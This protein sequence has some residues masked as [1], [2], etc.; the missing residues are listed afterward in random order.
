MSSRLKK[1]S[2]AERA[3]SV[4]NRFGKGGSIYVD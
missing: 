2:L 1:P 3:V 4:L